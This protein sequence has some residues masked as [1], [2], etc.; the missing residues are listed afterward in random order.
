M[1]HPGEKIVL[2]LRPSW[3]YYLRYFIFPALSYVLLSWLLPRPAFP[4]EFLFAFICVLISRYSNLYIVT[5]Q[6][7]LEQTGFIARNISESCIGNIKLVNVNQ[8]VIDRIFF[9]GTLKIHTAANNGAE[10][11]IVFGAIDD[12]LKVKE[13]LFQLKTWFRKGPRKRQKNRISRRR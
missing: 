2:S 6:R 1:V 9:L 5:N 3:L 8:G 10:G 12:P 7:V 11:D 4:F 13:L